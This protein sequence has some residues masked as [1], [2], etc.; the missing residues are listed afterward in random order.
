[1]RP[2]TE[3]DFSSRFKKTRQR[4]AGNF[5]RDIFITGFLID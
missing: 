3:N 5:S 2:P 4:V 1:M